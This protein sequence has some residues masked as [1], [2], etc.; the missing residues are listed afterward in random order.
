MANEKN[1]SKVTTLDSLETDV[2]VI[3]APKVAAIPVEGRNL[4]GEMV[5]VT[6]YPGEGEL[7]K[8]AVFLGHNEFA[9]Q[10]PRGTPV[11]LP[12]EVAQVLNDAVT[13]SY[14]AVKAGNE[15]IYEEVKTP[16]F[17]FSIQPA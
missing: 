3:E 15:T 6:I 1:Q 5:S 8:E 9:Y 17:A 13:V 12:K 10:I 4:S 16:R 7:G 11:K 2:A 14:K